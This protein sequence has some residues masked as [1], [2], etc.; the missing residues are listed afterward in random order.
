M[1]FLFVRW[2]NT[3]KLIKCKIVTVTAAECSWRRLQVHEQQAQREKKSILQKALFFEGRAKDLQSQDRQY[4]N[5]VTKLSCWDVEPYYPA[6]EVVYIICC[7]QL[8][9]TLGIMWFI[10]GLIAMKGSRSIIGFNLKP[11]TTRI[12]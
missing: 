6:R 7:P 3:V 12:R 8:D 2:A 9:V 5:N 1:I 10:R 4:P 11:L